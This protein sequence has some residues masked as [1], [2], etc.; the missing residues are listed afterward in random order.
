MVQSEGWPLF[1]RYARSRGK[2]YETVVRSQ[3]ASL[4]QIRY[5]QGRLDAQDEW[6]EQLTP[7]FLREVRRTIQ[8]AANA[9]TQAIQSDTVNS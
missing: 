5:A 1:Q 3:K 4:D 6:I 2:H 8:D 9:K 7:D